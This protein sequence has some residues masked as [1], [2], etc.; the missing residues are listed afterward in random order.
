MSWLA[1]RHPRPVP[2]YE[3]LYRGRSYAPKAY[4]QEIA[5]RVHELAARY[6]VGRASP[7]NTRRVAPREPVTAASPAE[8][9]AL[10]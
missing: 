3:R 9:L 4:Q 1:E 7:G 2:R 10:L 8:Q 5:A 6:G